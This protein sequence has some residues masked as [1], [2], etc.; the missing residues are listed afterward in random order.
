MEFIEL[1]AAVLLGK[2]N[3]ATL[4]FVTFLKDQPLPLDIAD[5]KLNAESVYIDFFFLCK[6]NF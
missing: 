5:E 4:N 3:T 1:F 6:E 2:F